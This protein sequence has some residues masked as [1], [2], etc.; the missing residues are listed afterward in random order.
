[1]SLM[2]WHGDYPS[3]GL[4]PHEV[5]ILRETPWFNNHA[6]DDGAPFLDFEN[7]DV[8]H[9]GE[10]IRLSGSGFASGDEIEFRDLDH[11]VR[12]VPTVIGP[13]LIQV[14]V[15]VGM[16]PGYIRAWRGDLRSDVVAVN[17]YP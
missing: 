12:V 9:W 13:T 16:G 2:K 1:M 14:T 6:F 4:L 17:F 3:T 5:M 11:F 10:T 7:Q 15:P 8:A